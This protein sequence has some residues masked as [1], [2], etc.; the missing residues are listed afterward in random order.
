MARTDERRP[1]AV[2]QVIVQNIGGVGPQIGAKNIGQLRAASSSVKYSV[3][4]GFVF[5]QVK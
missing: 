3:T 5:R 2:L 1:A 4:S